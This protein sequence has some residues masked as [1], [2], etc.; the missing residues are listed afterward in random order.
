ML[1]LE[2][3]QKVE[4]KGGN[5][6]QRTSNGEWASGAIYETLMG[7]GIKHKIWTS[8]QFGRIFRGNAL[9]LSAEFEPA[10]EPPPQHVVTSVV[11]LVQ[12]KRV[13]LLSELVEAG[14]KADDVRWMVAHRD[15]Y[16]PLD[17]ENFISEQCRIYID[18]QAYADVLFQRREEGAGSPPP[19]LIALPS[20]DQKIDWNG[21]SW[22]VVNDGNP[23]TLINGNGRLWNIQ[24]RDVWNY[25]TS[26]EWKYDAPVQPMQVHLS[27]AREHEALEKL[28]WF[29]HPGTRP[30]WTFGG[31][32]GKK[33]SDSS[34]ARAKAKLVAADLHGTSR[35]LA[36]ANSYDNC[37]N[38]S[39]W[40]DPTEQ[41]C[42]NHALDSAYLQNYRPRF[43][44]AISV[45]RI[46]CEQKNVEPRSESTLR[47]R[48][49]ELD[50]SEVV[51]LREG[52]F[53]AYQR[54][55]Y[56]PDLEIDWTI[57]G[58]IPWEVGHIDHAML[59]LWLRSKING[60]IVEAEAWRTVLRDA[61]TYRVLGSVFYFNR[62]SYIT[63]YRLVLD[64]VRRW[65]RLPRL[66][67][68]DNGPELKGYNFQNILAQLKVILLYRR[69]RQPRDGQTVESGF[70]KDVEIYT[71]NLPGNKIGEPPYRSQAAGFRPKDS[72]LHTLEEVAKL[73]T[74]GYYIEE[75]K[76]PSSR[77][78]GESIL[79]YESR[80]LKKYG[81]NHIR[82]V[83][84]DTDLIFDC[85]PG[86][87]RNGGNRIV[88]PDGTVETNGFQY[89]SEVFEKHGLLGSSVIPRIDP[90]NCG[91]VFCWAQ[92][93]HE[94]IECQS[95]EYEILC[96]FTHAERN[97]IETYLTQSGHID[98][99]IPRRA[100]AETIARGIMEL[101]GDAWLTQLHDNARQGYPRIDGLVF[102]DGKPFIDIPAVSEPT[103]AEVTPDIQSIARE[104]AQ[105]MR[106]FE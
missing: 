89:F 47:K 14:F 15:V 17:T 86:V 55:K 80:L 88:M 8:E 16:F 32:K 50:D 11:N 7:L 12:A 92:G 77:T 93:S 70:K 9:L 48:L 52:Q 58:R 28:A 53:V 26:K 90:E 68:C 69:V 97:E 61:C 66:I 103:V 104:A 64:V 24:L 73:F 81:E 78:Y 21:Q 51:E 40:V 29:T 22:I 71:A 25:V 27:P 45:Y 94:W 100:L 18:E 84:Y 101:R 63:L 95:K 43:S 65:Q 54:G 85:M 82:G 56:T 20:K 76:Y 6:Y 39:T 34:I 83:R 106:D 31:R 49:A 87:E 60:E 67:I 1:R 10:R 44:Y 72:A 38:R 91:R 23:Y 36:L 2:K 30:I 62:P 42:W 59:K 13:V 79:A 102:K 3:L 4:S 37:G 33:V 99:S 35:I 105:R 98:K 57:K 96:E 19:A 5:L 74:T 46:L 41:E 75:P